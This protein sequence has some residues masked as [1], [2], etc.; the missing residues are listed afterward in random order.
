M[1]GLKISEDADRDHVLCPTCGTE[2]EPMEFNGFAMG[3]NNESAFTL[4]LRDC[5]VITSDNCS[6]HFKNGRPYFCPHCNELLFVYI[7][8]DLRRCKHCKFCGEVKYKQSKYAP[9]FCTAN[10]NGDLVFKTPEPRDIATGTGCTWYNVPFGLSN[11]GW[12]SYEGVNHSHCKHIDDE[13]VWTDPKMR[14]FLCKHYH[15]MQYKDH[16]DEK[17]DNDCN[18][19]VPDNMISRMVGV[20][21][22]FEA[23]YGKYCKYREQFE[24]LLILPEDII[25]IPKFDKLIELEKKNA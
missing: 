7:E 24:G 22:E 1:K 23:D 15:S 9:A 18:I 20:C 4:P 14:C 19:D 6:Q 5:S 11:R 16:L 8:M 10:E 21:S 25:S 13:P 3:S 12:G 2:L 17:C